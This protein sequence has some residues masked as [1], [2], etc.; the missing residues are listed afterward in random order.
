MW[1]ARL[2]SRARKPFAAERLH[3]DD[4]ARHA[5][6]DVHVAGAYA[7]RDL[8]DLAVDAAVHAEGEAVAGGID[9]IH[10]AIE[11]SG[12][13][14]CDVQYRP[15][16]FTLQLRG[17]AQL[18]RARREER[19][20]LAFRGRLRDRDFFCARAQTG[21]VREQHGERAFID[22]RADVGGKLRGVPQ[23]QFLH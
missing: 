4:G 14:A 15:E 21:D 5:A 20:A 11:I 18:E 1:A 12:A 22:Y 8:R 2:W 9:G 7:L 23:A 16:H 10:H 13:I 6:I 3:A 17:V 19:A